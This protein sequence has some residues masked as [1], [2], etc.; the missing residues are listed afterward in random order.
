M[1]NARANYDLFKSLSKSIKKKYL[2]ELKLSY[3]MDSFAV[4]LG[5]RSLHDLQDSFDYDSNLLRAKAA[6]FSAEVMHVRNVI[7]IG[8][9]LYPYPVGE[10]Q[11]LERSMMIVYNRLL[12]AK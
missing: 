11:Y 9:S 10:N 2:P 6:I 4:S 7:E 5:F 1:I 8:G 12:S 3:V